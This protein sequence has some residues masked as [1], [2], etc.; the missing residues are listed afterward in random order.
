MEYI[1]VGD[2][3]GSRNAW[4]RIDPPN[5]DKVVFVGDYVD[6]KT[7]T[8]REILGKLLVIMKLKIQYS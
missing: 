8:D 3:H 5:Y 1:A 6:G 2:I 7:A 4:K